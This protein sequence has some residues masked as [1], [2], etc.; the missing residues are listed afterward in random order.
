M[1]PGASWLPNQWGEEAACEEQGAGVTCR[2]R[3]MG[4]RGQR[5]RGR[6]AGVRVALHHEG[7]GGV[8]GKGHTHGQRPGSRAELPGGGG[9]SCVSCLGLRRECNHRIL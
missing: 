6:K 1:G 4:Q 9:K 8:Q 2:G 5:K 7:S 3:Q